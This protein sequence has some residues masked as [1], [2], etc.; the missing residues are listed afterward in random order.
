MHCLLRSGFNFK[1]NCPCLFVPWIERS[2]GM[3]DTECRFL[4]A[5]FNNSRSQCELSIMRSSIGVR[6]LSEARLTQRGFS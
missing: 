1:I 4:E 6:P 2:C 3:L 5:S